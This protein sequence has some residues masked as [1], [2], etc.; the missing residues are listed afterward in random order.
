MATT[1]YNGDWRPRSSAGCSDTSPTKLG[2]VLDLET[3]GLDP[4]TDE[5]IEVAMVPFTYTEN[6][7]VIEML[8]AFNRL[9]EPSTPIPAKITALTG[10]DD[11]MVKGHVIDPAE[12]A[13]AVAPLDLIVAHNAR[14]D[15]PFAERFHESFVAKAM[16]VLDGAGAM[17]GS[18]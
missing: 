11:A 15:R 14:F 3:T 1:R 16:G 10:I 17:G 4:T 13:A 5:I 12:I 8:P 9:R 6:G 18:G 2:A 7:R